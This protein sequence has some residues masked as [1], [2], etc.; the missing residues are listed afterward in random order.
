MIVVELE[1]NGVST[2]L[3]R[4]LSNRLQQVLQIDLHLQNADPRGTVPAPAAAASIAAFCSSAP[5]QPHSRGVRA[6][7]IPTA[8]GSTVAC[9]ASSCASVS[10]ASPARQPAPPTAPPPGHPTA[11]PGHPT[12]PPAR[13]LMCPRA[14][15]A[16]SP[17]SLCG[18]ELQRGG[19][20]RRWQAATV[21][22]LRS[23]RRPPSP[24]SHSARG[25]FLTST[26]G[27]ADVLRLDFR[28]AKHGSAA[29]IRLGFRV[30]RRSWRSRRSTR[31][32]RRLQEIGGP[33]AHSSRRSSIRSTALDSLRERLG[34][35]DSRQRELPLPAG[36]NGRC[37][38][39]LQMREI[40]GSRRCPPSLS[41]AQNGR[42]CRCTTTHRWRRSHAHS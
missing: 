1:D 40:A 29:L 20:P 10:P 17:P 34:V 25:R 31:R 13:L 12:V 4:S 18:G 19:A 32:W 23:W 22:K 15:S 9:S 42:F 30:A 3:T 37:G 5:A 11:P 28:V 7:P 6:F 27:D 35:V 39:G 2:V 14:I 33:H 26:H 36:A 38:M 41:L 8:A 16:S 24:S 21:G